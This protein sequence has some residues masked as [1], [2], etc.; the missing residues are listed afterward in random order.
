MDFA[1][2]LGH[3]NVS[4]MKS[5]CGLDF[6]FTYID[7]ILIFCFTLD[8]HRDHLHQYFK[9]LELYGLN[10]GVPRCHS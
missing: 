2:Q 5:A 1:T 4:W 7:D 8:E 10:K 9:R 6:V 3:S